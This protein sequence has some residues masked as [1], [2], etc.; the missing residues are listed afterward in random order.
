MSKNIAFFGI[1]SAAALALG[2]IEHLIP[3]PLPVP[4][5]KLGLANI[6]VLVA[7]Y[8]RSPREAF[9]VASAKVLLGGLLYGGVSGIIYGLSGSMLSLAAMLALKKTKCFSVAGVSVVGGVF[10]N[11]GQ[12][13]AAAVVV[14]NPGMFHYLPVMILSGT[15]AGLA[16]GLCAAR[17]NIYLKTVGYYV[18]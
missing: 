6:V 13:C 4:G 8:A 18:R 14:S 3:L 10:H 2:Y 16:C 1:M 15:A 5:V 12:L 17:V 11:I 7:L 9:G